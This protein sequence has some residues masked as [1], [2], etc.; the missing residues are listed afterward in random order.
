MCKALG[1]QKKG[2]LIMIKLPR[3]TYGNSHDISCFNHDFIMIYH[4]ITMVIAMV[5]SLG[6]KIILKPGL[7]WTMLVHLFSWNCNPK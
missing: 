4:D 1:E 2:S 6:Y 7:L 3:Y 5:F